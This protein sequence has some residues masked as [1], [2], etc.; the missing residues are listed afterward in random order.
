[1]T[2]NSE[3]NI[4]SQIAFGNKKWGI[5]AGYRYGQCGAKFRTATEYAKS[6]QFHQSCTTSV[7]ER[8]DADSHSVSFNAFWQPEE[9]GWIPSISAGVGK[10]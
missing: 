2:D 4:T 9:S 5:A 8:S 1:M 6:N 3:G 7:D 10:S